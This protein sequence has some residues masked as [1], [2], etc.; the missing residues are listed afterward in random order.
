MVPPAD[1]SCQIRGWVKSFFIAVGLHN[2]AKTSET[3]DLFA[4]CSNL[5]SQIIRASLI[6]QNFDKLDVRGSCHKP[7]GASPSVSLS[8]HSFPGN[9]LCRKIP[10]G[11]HNSFFCPLESFPDFCLKFIIRQPYSSL[12]IPWTEELCSLMRPDLSHFFC[13][14]NSESIVNFDQSTKCKLHL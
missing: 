1:T 5:W 2:L 12:P 4:C 14:E 7:D 13:S 10:W 8:T 9:H 11:S 3:E 6:P